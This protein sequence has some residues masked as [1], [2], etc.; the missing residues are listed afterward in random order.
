M[1]RCCRAGA[2]PRRSSARSRPATRETGVCL[3]QMEKGLDTGPVLLSQTH[4]RSARTKPAASCTTAS[5][6]SARRC[7]PTA[8]A[9]CAPASRPVP[10]P[11]PDD[12]VT[13]AHKL[14]KAEAQARLV[15]AGRRAGAQGAR[16][17]SLAD[18]R[19]AGRRRAPAHPRRDRAA[20][21]RT[22]PRPARC[23]A[24]AATASTSPAARARCA[25]ACCSAKA[26]RRSPPP[27]TSTPVAT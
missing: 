27:T 22:A 1:P 15:A 18:G 2:A 10:Q 25:S 13:Y 12:G 9:C 19:G 24:P 11:Q 6:H 4:R 5:P 7:S 17:Q 8:W 16:L 3:M 20:A 23:C 21:A 26:A 14:D